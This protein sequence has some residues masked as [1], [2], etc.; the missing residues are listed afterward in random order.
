LMNG[1]PISGIYPDGKFS[2]QRPSLSLSGTQCVLLKITP[3]KGG[4]IDRSAEYLASP[5]SLTIEMGNLIEAQSYNPD[6][7]IQPLAIVSDG[8]KVAQLSYF[9]YLY[10]ASKP[11]G[12]DYW[13]HFLSSE[14]V[15]SRSIQDKLNAATAK[16]GAA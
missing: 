13:R 10:R 3:N 14:P 15:F 8:G 7:W 9:N 1:E 12:K 4:T 6:Q 2:T 5:S 16:E 11:R